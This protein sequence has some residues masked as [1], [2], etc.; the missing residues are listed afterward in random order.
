MEPDGFHGALVDATTLRCVLDSTTF[1]SND[2]KTPM[3]SP[4]YFSSFYS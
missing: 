4:F 3:I 2:S 1:C